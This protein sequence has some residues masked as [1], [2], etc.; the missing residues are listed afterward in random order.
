MSEICLTAIKLLFLLGFTL[1]NCEEAIWLPKWSRYAKR[2]HEP[3]ESNEFIF[4]VIIVTIIGYLL[5][6]ADFI[7][8]STGNLIN[9]IYLGFIGM[10]GL[11]VIFPHLLASIV[12]KKY[13]PGLLTGIMLNLP[14]SI[15]II[16]WHI[17]NGVKV[18]YLLAAIA[19]VG[20]SVL[21]SLKYFFLIG[22]KLTNY[23]NIEQSNKAIPAD[24]KS[25]AAE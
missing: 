2:F 14:F 18:I 6:A 15:I 25:R 3:V 17:Q 11:N 16:Y 1:H 23:L 21:S 20:I 4:A 9:Y 8:G 12:L 22:G 5:T 10:M 13:A 24:A 7:L 19:I